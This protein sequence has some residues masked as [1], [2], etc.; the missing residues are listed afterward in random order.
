MVAVVAVAAIARSHCPLTL[1]PRRCAAYAYTRCPPCLC[2]LCVDRVRFS[3]IIPLWGRFR[4]LSVRHYSAL[5]PRAGDCEAFLLDEAARDGRPVAVELVG[6]V[7]GL[8]GEHEARIVYPLWAAWT[9][10]LR[11]GVPR[12]PGRCRVRVR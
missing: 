4:A 8:A 12:A 9:I 7:R 6:T 5:C 1:A 3:G 10:A 11:R 2:V